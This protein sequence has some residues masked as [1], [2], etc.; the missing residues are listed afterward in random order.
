MFRVTL[1]SSTPGFH[2][3]EAYSCSE[4]LLC[5]AATA[6][7]GCESQ[8]GPRYYGKNAGFSQHCCA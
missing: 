1:L 2:K 8:H 4:A 7:E 5:A 6:A 3:E